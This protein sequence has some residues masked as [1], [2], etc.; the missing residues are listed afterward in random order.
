MVWEWNGYVISTTSRLFG[1]NCVLFYD[2]YSSLL[3]GAFLENWTKFNCL[4]LI[5]FSTHLSPKITASFPGVDNLIVEETR[6]YEGIAVNYYE[7]LMYVLEN[8]TVNKIK[9]MMLAN[10]KKSP[11]V[12]CT[13]V[14]IAV[15]F[16]DR[17]EF[18]HKTPPPMWNL[19]SF[20]VFPSFIEDVEQ[21][22]QHHN[23]FDSSRFQEASQS[24][25]SLNLIYKK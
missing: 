2:L 11:I 22:F 21:E 8:K 3:F 19:L 7:I 20:F 6:P 15:L 9:I 1:D 17:K 14:F 4:T 24:P 18:V 12:L 16:I 5:T 25:P 13:W 23:L 10:R